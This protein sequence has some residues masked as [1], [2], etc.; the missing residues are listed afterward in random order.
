VSA[1]RGKPYQ[2]GGEHR[3]RSGPLG[4]RPF[5]VRLQRW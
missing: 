1:G 5:H 2:H 3:N 4:V